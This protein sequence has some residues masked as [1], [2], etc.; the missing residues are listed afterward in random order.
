MI[1][2][3]IA[4]GSEL[5]TPFRSDTNSLAITAILNDIGYEVRGKFV[6]G[7][8]V[9]ELA[10]VVA[11]VMGW[12]DLLVVTGGLGPTED[13]ITREAVARAFDLPLDEAPALVERLQQRFASRGLTMA[14]INRRQ[15]MVPRG[16][17]VLENPL[18]TAPGLWLER[19]TGVAV[20][21]PGPPREMRPM[22]ERLVEQSLGPRGGG[23]ALFR[24]V[25]KITGRTES[26]VDTLA[27]PIYG[28]WASGPTPITT[29]ILAVF[30][31]IELH[32][33]VRAPGRDAADRLLAPLVAELRAALGPSV[34][35]ADGETLE[36]VV[37]AVLVE[38]GWRVAVAESCTGGLL[39]S[40]LTDVPGSSRYLERGLVCYSNA[41]KVELAGVPP[42][43]I[44][45]HGAVSEPVA[46][47]MAEGVRARAGADVGIGVTGIAGPD[48]GTPEK[49]VGTVVLSVATAAETRARTVRLVGTRE[50]VKFQATQAALNLLRLVLLPDRPA[51]S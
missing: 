20:L 51:A 43:T 26:D 40:R 13:D 28:R 50:Q 2:A 23:T 29:T 42:E 18:G 48:G 5:L 46:R 44:A 8:R 4:V 37:G 1:A 10:R 35:S 33:A 31:Q 11:D 22:L 3:I 7:D 30:G 38:R 39:A 14:A 47:A 16:A 34:Y 15:A 19:G 9:D 21:L 45:S 49:P 27:Q 12:A 36:A 24:R 41:A 32:L 25:L 17:V 6:V